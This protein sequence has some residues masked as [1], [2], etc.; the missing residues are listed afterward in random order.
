M[1]PNPQVPQPPQLVPMANNLNAYPT[2]WN[3]GMAGAQ[4]GRANA[5]TALPP[6]EETEGAGNAFSR[7]NMGM[8]VPTGYAMGQYMYQRAAYPGMMQGMMINGQMTPSQVVVPTTYQRA[9]DPA[10]QYTQQMLV[11]LRDSIYPSQREWAVESLG[12]LD[13][14]M[15]PSV[16][17]AVLTA[18]KEDPA[19][20]VR[21]A[22]VRCLVK[23][24]VNTVPVVSAL[25][26]LKA[27]I[28]PRVRCE[29]EQAMTMLGQARGGQ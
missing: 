26:G 23:M 10:P 11:V 21:A 1:A 7:Q 20:T 3:G 22:C 19:A 8:P 2:P 27:D 4:A 13:W 16:L 17:Q 14:R 9:A 24:N 5:F 6:T 15:N 29:V 25:E 28:D 18:A 12:E